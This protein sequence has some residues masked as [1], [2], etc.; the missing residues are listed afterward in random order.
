M[1]FPP[2]E[3]GRKVNLLPLVLHLQ[4]GQLEGVFPCCGNADAVE[5]DHELAQLEPKDLP[6]G[7]PRVGGDVETDHLA[8]LVTMS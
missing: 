1:R 3:L 7:G 5:P 6:Q 2:V 4:Q 8:H